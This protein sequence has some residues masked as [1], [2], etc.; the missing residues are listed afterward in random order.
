[1]KHQKLYMY[2][3]LPAVLGLSIAGV[4]IASAHGMFGGFGMVSNLTPDEIASRGQT[5][6][7]NEAN[8]LGISVDDV[9]SGWAQGQTIMQ[10]AEAHGITQEQLQKKM[11]DQRVQNLKTQLQTLVDKGIITQAQADQRIT[12]MQNQVQNGKGKMGMRGWH[13]GFGFF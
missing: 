12:F 13:R 7:Q 9:K 6:F 1:M 2:T 11:K 4:Q 10:I 5:M 8:L 3:I